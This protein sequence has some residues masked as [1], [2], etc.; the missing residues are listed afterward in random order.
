[1]VR[2]RA[3]VGHSH[4]HGY[5]PIWL[6]ASSGRRTPL[7]W[8][9]QRFCGI[10]LWGLNNT[11]RR[12]STKNMH[13]KTVPLATSVLALGQCGLTSPQYVYPRQQL[14]SHSVQVRGL[15]HSGSAECSTVIWSYRDKTCAIDGRQW[16]KRAHSAYML[17]TPLYST[18]QNNIWDIL[19]NKPHCARSFSH[20]VGQPHCLTCRTEEEV[21]RVS[22][23]LVHRV[24]DGHLSVGEGAEG[25]LISWTHLSL[26]VI[27]Q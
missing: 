8:T 5:C 6:V 10:P 16:Q 25:L 15:G 14:L 21:L 9:Q 24:S 2:G 7:L 1:M 20:S 11:N 26:N 22:Q 18:G 4:L 13:H 17:K 27:K 23:V 19:Q 12:V 3:F